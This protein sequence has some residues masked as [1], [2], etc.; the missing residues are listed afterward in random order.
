MN[1]DNLIAVIAV[2]ASILI[3]GALAF[4]GAA[5]GIAYN[6]VPVM[7]GLALLAFVIQWIAFIPAFLFKTEKFY[8]LT[9]SVTYL[10]LALT[11]FFLQPAPDLRSILIT[12]FICVWAGRLGLFLFA[13]VLRA[14]EDSRFAN[15]RGRFLRFL[16]AW[17]LQGLWVVF[18]I[19]AGLAAVTSVAP[20]SFDIFAALGAA[21]WVIGFS[22]EASA[23]R[24]KRVFRAKPENRGKFISSGL[25]AAS[26]HPNYFGEIVLW[27]GIAIMA[28]PVLQGWQYLTLVSPV[29]VAILLTKISGI[30]LLE[31][32]ADRK[33]GGQADY[34]EYKRSTPVLVPRPVRAR[35]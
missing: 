18:S 21:V 23:D 7:V 25:W 28:L 10:S 17:S 13:R 2:V 29:F 5:N 16:M 26:R 24:Q 14:G 27:T 1:K 4:A 30:P 31:E 20:R 19:A 34:E 8:D 6:G 15:V 3:G 33:W 12:A 9:G 32:A 22:I 11:A 35:S